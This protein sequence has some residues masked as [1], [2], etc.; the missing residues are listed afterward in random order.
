VKTIN[1]LAKVIKFLLNIKLKGGVNPKTPPLRTPLI[2]TVA[3][4]QKTQFKIEA[5]R[6]LIMS[7]QGRR[8]TK[9]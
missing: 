4:A 5:F 7:Q 8:K 3:G 9:R 1:L 2:R 6:N